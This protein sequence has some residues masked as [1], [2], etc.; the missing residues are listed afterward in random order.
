LA[1]LEDIISD[2]VAYMRANYETFDK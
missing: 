1:V 2:G